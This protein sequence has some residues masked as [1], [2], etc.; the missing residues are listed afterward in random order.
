MKVKGV[1]Q[2]NIEYPCKWTYTIIGSNEQSIREVVS[3]VMDGKDYYLSFSRESRGSKYIS[4]N[5]EISVSSE[6]ERN[7]IYSSLCN[8]ASVKVVL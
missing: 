4:M 3:E 8:N 6:F 1:K 7:K 5:A 2:T